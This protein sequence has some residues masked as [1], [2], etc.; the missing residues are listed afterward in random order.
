MTIFKQH[1]RTTWCIAAGYVAAALEAAALPRLDDRREDLRQNC[2]PI[3][4]PLP[5]ATAD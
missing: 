1:V 3:V 5:S 4:A 2:E